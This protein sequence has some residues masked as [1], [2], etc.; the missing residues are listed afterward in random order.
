MSHCP[1]NIEDRTPIRR[2]CRSQCETLRSY[3]RGSKYLELKIYDFLFEAI[4]DEISQTLIAG[5]PTWAMGGVAHRD[6]G[7]FSR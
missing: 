5:Y 1:T 7:K 6:T 3:A 4:I 2:D